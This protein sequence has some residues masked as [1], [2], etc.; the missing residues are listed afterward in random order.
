LCRL[1]VHSWI[2]L[3]LRR[4]F[5]LFNVPATTEIYTL[6][7]HD[8]LPIWAPGD[9]GDRGLDVNDG[10]E[11]YSGAGECVFHPRGGK[12]DDLSGDGELDELVDRLGGLAELGRPTCPVTCGEP[13]VAAYR[14]AGLSDDPGVVE[15]F[16]Y[17]DGGAAGEPVPCADHRDPWDVVDLLDAQ[18]VVGDGRHDERNVHI[19]AV[20]PGGRVA[21]VV[22]GEFQLRCRVTLPERAQGAGGWFD[23]GP[24]DETDPQG[25]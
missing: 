5:F 19:P 17:R 12:P 7:L 2:P 18:A 11:S 21:E 15:Q 3:C 13:E 16:V 24:D 10:Y 22:V 25:S 23:L 4:V 14:V 9:G 6:S 20:E 1:V 8:A